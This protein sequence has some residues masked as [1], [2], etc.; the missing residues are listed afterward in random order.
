VEIQIERLLPVFVAGFA[1]TRILELF[2]AIRVAR[3][4]VVSKEHKLLVM[5]IGSVIIATAL[6]LLGGLSVLPETNSIYKKIFDVLVT[7]FVVSA[8]TEGANSILKFLNYK[9]EETE[10]KAGKAEETLDI[11]RKRSTKGV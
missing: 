4:K 7:I 6:V 11:L 2:D 9:K 1:V 10:A 3:G 8:G 5:I